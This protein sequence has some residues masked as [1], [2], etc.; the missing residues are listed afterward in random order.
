MTDSLNLDAD[1]LDACAKRLAAGDASACEALVAATL[2]EVR[3]FVAAK[4]SS[5]E[6]VDEVVQS[7]YVTAMEHI[8]DYRG[9]GVIIPW[10]KGIA[11]NE[12]RRL[13]RER[14]KWDT[15]FGGDAIEALVASVAVDGLDTEEAHWH[16]ERLRALAHCV[17]QVAEPGRRLLDHC[18]R[19]GWSME[20][21]AKASGSSYEAVA[22]AL[23]RLR[24]KIR[25]C[26]D[27][28]AVRT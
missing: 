12:L 28:Q 25:A 11:R 22:Q 2:R 8:A 15:A 6:L 19:D 10:L 5:R 17:G 3:I 23:S 18:Y 7:T 27:Q 20:Q 1:A 9:P 24:K 16:D 13:L 21:I 14:A 26:I 4:G